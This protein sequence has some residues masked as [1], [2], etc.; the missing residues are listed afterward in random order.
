MP[1]E[2]NLVDGAEFGQ[3]STTGFVFYLF[4]L[5]KLIFK[6]NKAKNIKI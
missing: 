4:F 2:S 1:I 5:L 3:S 6:K